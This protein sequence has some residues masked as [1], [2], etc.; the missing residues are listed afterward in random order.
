[1]A[2][3]I[4]VMVAGTDGENP[5]KTPYI[6]RKGAKLYGTDPV[7]MESVMRGV[8][9]DAPSM[10]DHLSLEPYTTVDGDLTDKSLQHKMDNP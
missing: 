3:V 6:T 8:I 7:F 9:E 4:C 10:A 5:T 1:M 2:E